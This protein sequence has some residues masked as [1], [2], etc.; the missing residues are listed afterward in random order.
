M[1]SFRLENFDQREVNL[2]IL[3]SGLCLEM[4]FPN[5]D[6]PT[7]RSDLVIIRKEPALPAPVYVQNFPGELI[8]VNSEYDRPWQYVY[9]LAHELGH[10]A[11]RGD[12]RYLRPDGNHWIE[13]TISGAFSVMAM[14]AIAGTPGPLQGGAQSYLDSLL[15][16]QYRHDDVDGAW[17][18]DQLGGFRQAEALTD[19]VMKLSG[20]IASRITVPQIVAD[21][22]TLIGLELNLDLNDFL[23]SWRER[24]AG[25]NSVPSLLLDLH[26]PAAV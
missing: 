9:Q 4:F 11:A 7:L 1:V 8:I 2:A 16:G 5:G 21:A 20:Y 17:F 3:A 19:V 12:L 24:C 10:L 26:T 18:A 13:E 15:S 14:T 23:V 25:P 22:R 6:Y